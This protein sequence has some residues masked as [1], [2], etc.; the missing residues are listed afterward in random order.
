M[1][2]PEGEPAL[3]RVADAIFACAAAMR[4]QNALSERAVACS[5]GLYELGKGNMRVSQALERKLL[6]EGDGDAGSADR[7]T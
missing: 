2:V 6:S 5:E 1:A 4:T 7:G 3:N